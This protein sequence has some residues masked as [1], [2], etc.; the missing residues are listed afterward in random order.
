MDPSLRVFLG[1]DDHILFQPA[2]AT[3]AGQPL[4]VFN[5]FGI[6]KIVGGTAN[7]LQVQ[8]FTRMTSE[9]LLRYSLPPFTMASYPIASLGHMIKVLGQDCCVNVERS[10][11]HDIAYVMPL[12]EVK[13]GLFKMSGCCNCFFIRYSLYKGAIIPTALEMRSNLFAHFISPICISPIWFY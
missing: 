9:I 5:N 7:I 13:S 10:A 12:S 2:E 6:R 4:L 1:Y 8:V 3:V 11:I